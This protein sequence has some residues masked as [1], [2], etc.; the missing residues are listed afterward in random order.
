MSD[1]ELR[2][3]KH[4]EWTEVA[5]LIY[6]STNA[7]Y[8]GNGKSAIFSGPKTN[9][10]LFCEVYESLDQESCIIAVD[11]ESGKI[12]GSCFM[13]PRE[14]HVSLGIMNV[15]PDHFGRGI[16]VKILR[17][18]TDY[19]DKHGLPI[20]LVSSAMNLDSFSL[21]NRAGFVPR[22]VFQD[23]IMKVPEEGFDPPVPDGHSIRK[24]EISDVPRM[25]DLEMEISGIRRE[26]D[27]Q[28]FITNSQGLWHVSVLEDSNGQLVGFLVS[29]GHPASTM[30]GPGIMR[31]EADATALIMAEL[32]QHR[33]K[34]P[35]WLI[36]S[37]YPELV[38]SMYA[39]GAKNCELHFAQCRGKWTP[40]SGIVMPTFMPE[41][42]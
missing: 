21:Y 28:F 14:T 7:W 6:D 4:D 37:E 23:M 25:A 2:R 3:M 33:S 11:T 29:V 42:G 18:I 5:E 17:E 16:A 9:A 1:L 38:K 30:L 41:T 15:H 20:R 13:H 24:A 19:A 27:Y 40:S 39:I 26:R 22:A 12:V 8:V 34:M 31:T 10:L 36:P 32:N 35:V